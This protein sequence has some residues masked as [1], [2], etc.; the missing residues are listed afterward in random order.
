MSHV[1]SQRHNK[2]KYTD[3]GAGPRKCF[4]VLTIQGSVSKYLA[5]RAKKQN[6]SHIKQEHYIDS[7][8]D[9]GKQ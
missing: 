8:F 6:Y 3:T 9:T 7:F 1:G 4:L 2:K 5:H